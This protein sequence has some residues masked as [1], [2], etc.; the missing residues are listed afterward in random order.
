M[1]YQILI[2]LCLALILSACSSVDLSKLSDADLARISNASVVCNPPYMRLGLTCCLDRNNNSICDSDEAT[3]SAQP[4]ANPAVDIQAALT[5]QDA[6][7][8]HSESSTAPSQGA[9]PTAAATPPETTRSSQPP[10]SPQSTL[11]MYNLT[12]LPAG[13][14][15]ISISIEA[16]AKYGYYTSTGKVERCSPTSPPSTSTSNTTAS[17]ASPTPSSL[18]PPI[19]V[20]INAS[21]YIIMSDIG[22]MTFISI[23]ESK[24]AY[25]YEGPSGAS[26]ANTNAAWIRTFG[27]YRGSGCG[28][29]STTSSTVANCSVAS[30]NVYIPNH[31]SSLQSDV[32]R[33]FESEINRSLSSTTPGAHES[34]VM[35][36]GQLINKIESSGTDGNREVDIWTSGATL[37]EIYGDSSHEITT[38]YLTKYPSNL[39][40]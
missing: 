22:D 1:K 21:N 3:G 39:T 37:I 14:N 32:N 16:R 40:G 35:I 33:L 29:S 19:P 4:A 5:T 30:V 38:E 27:Y 36:N 17:S 25:Y 6:R 12:M 15:C 31:D 10:Q 2:L 24:N 23:P 18:P 28:N 9:T 34:S 8:I 11:E 20:G 26:S 13:Y 7:P